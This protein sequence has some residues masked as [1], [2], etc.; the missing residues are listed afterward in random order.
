MRGSVFCEISLQ[1]GQHEMDNAVVKAIQ[2]AL[3]PQLLEESVRLA[4]GQIEKNR[5]TQPKDKEILEQGLLEIDRRIDHLA[6][7]IAASGGSATIYGKLRA[8]EDRKRVLENRLA[9]S[10]ETAKAVSL[11]SAKMIEELRMRI[12]DLRGL[13]TRQVSEARNVLKTAL[14]GSLILQPVVIG[15]RKG[16]RFHGTGSYGSLL[17]YSQATNDGGG[18]QGS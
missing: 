5:T 9:V 3:D 14:N 1:I 16:Y 17:A 6:E 8:E 4:I 10:S 13:L 7:A 11:D 15:G 18:G 12:C 2:N